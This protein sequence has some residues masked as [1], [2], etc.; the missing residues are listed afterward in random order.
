MVKFQAWHFLI[1]PSLVLLHLVVSPYTKVE[2]SFNIQAV[3]DV[4]T[5]GVPTSNAHYKFKALYDHMTFSGSVPRTFVGALV[6]SAI[7]QP[8]VWLGGFEGLKEQSIGRLPSWWQRTHDGIMI[9]TH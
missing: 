4:L 3:H 9:L 5:Y 8:F 7:A 2:E 6:T 1:I